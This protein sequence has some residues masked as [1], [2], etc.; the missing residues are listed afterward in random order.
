MCMFNL[1]KSNRAM[2][3]CMYVCIVKVFSSLSQINIHCPAPPTPT[4]V[5]A[6]VINAS[7][8]RVTWQWTG[9]GPAPDCFDTTSVTSRSE[10]GDESSLQ[11]SDPAATEATLSNLQCSTNYTV[12]VVA[13]AGL[14]RR[15][16]IASIVLQGV[17]SMCVSKLFI[18][19]KCGHF[20]IAQIYVPQLT[21]ELKPL[22]T[23]HISECHGSG[24]ARAYLCV[25]IS[26][27]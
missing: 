3:V 19:F 10:G 13:T 17:T 20:P 9:S 24:H 5:T 4:E 1:R 16:S 23:A 18:A 27:E 26:L 14:Y 25:L 22:L 6:Q 8:I 15:K 7:S 12:T 21:W 2:Y 11:L